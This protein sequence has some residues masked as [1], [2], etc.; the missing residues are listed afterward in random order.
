MGTES[1]SYDEAIGVIRSQ[2]ALA[3][4]TP[5]QPVYAAGC[6]GQIT[7]Y[8]KYAEVSTDLE[9]FSHI[10]V[11]YHSHRAGPAQSKEKP[12][13]RMWSMASSPLAPLAA[14]IPSASV[15]SGC[16]L[17]GV[18]CSKWTAWT[19][20]TARRSWTS[21]PTSEIRPHRGNAGRLAGSRGR[22][23]RPAAGKPELREPRRE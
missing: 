3:D 9:G 15:L 1:I 14:P 18:T 8:P 7:V 12:S 10:Y 16:S 21:S 22:R 6:R 20:W 2:H 11:I 23:D 17:G 19:S 4:K 13:S 5:I